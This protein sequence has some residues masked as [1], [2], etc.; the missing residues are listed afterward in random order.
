MRDDFD[1]VDTMQNVNQY[2]VKKRDLK[3]ARIRVFRHLLYIHVP[4]KRL[5]NY[6]SI[7][8]TELY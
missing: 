7:N 3:I 1:N 6:I 2:D 4:T 5:R 8:D